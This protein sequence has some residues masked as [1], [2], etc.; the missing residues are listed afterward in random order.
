M[1]ISGGKIA[2]IVV[3]VL[4]VV[5]TTLGYYMQL[6]S[7]RSAVKVVRVKILRI[8]IDEENL[9][10]TYVLSIE[11]ECGLEEDVVIESYRASIE[12]YYDQHMLLYSTL[13]G[14]SVSFRQRTVIIANETK[15]LDFS[16]LETLRSVY[17]ENELLAGDLR[18]T[19]TLSIKGLHVDIDTT[20]SIE[21]VYP[22]DVFV[23]KSS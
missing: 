15:L 3:I 19:A 12:L 18:F 5:V 16:D 14:G 21:P 6:N 11:I 1:R 23:F 4:V 20:C 13:A 22:Q 10:L 17:S 9:S 7:V 8:I 2:I